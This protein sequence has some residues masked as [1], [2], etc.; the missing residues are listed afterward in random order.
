MCRPV[1]TAKIWEGV[2]RS[3]ERWLGAE[4]E[5]PGD[6]MEKRAPSP[7]ESALYVP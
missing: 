6:I 3:G 2:T 4:R 1:S 5:T 7:P